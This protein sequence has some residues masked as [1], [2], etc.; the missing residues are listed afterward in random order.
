[1][2]S[3]IPMIGHVTSSY[4]SAN[5]GRSF[6]LALVKGGRQK[7]GE[8]VYVPLADGV[9]RAKITSPVFIDPEGA[10]IDG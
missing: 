8:S 2:G 7:I 10:K 6:A 9:V 5:L 3:R 1:M 4:H